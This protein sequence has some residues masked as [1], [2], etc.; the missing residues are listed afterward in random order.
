MKTFK[1]SKYAT[2]QN[3]KQTAEMLMLLNGS[4]TTL[5]VKDF[6]RLDGFIAYQRQVS[7]MMKWIQEEYDWSFTCNGVF[8][9]YQFKIK[10][11]FSIHP[12][13][14]PFGLN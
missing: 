6:L 9:S 5:E 2:L 7:D 4:T 12:D 1:T 13:I 14:P 10:M 8:R 11:D 3:V